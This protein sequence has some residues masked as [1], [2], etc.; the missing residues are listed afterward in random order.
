MATHLRSLL[1]LLLLVAF[2]VTS[3]GILLRKL[4]NGLATGAWCHLLRR[5]RWLQSLPWQPTPLARIHLL[6]GAGRKR[7]KTMACSWKSKIPSPVLGGAA[8]THTMGNEASQP[9][10]DGHGLRDERNVEE[11]DIPYSDFWQ[12]MDVAG[13]FTFSV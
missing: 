3:P 12:C 7:K 1:A 6:C 5:K 4:S 11:L 10:R 13:E 8:A 2:A 9:R